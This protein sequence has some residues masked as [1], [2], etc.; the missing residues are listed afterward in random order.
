MQQQI[1][2][3]AMK[4]VQKLLQYMS[5]HLEVC[6]KQYS[7]LITEYLQSRNDDNWWDYSYAKKD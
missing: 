4:W 6:G 3:E 2:C 1:I 7:M 5:V